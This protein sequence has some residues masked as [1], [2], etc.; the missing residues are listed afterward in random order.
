[1]TLNHPDSS[2]PA[3]AAAAA[4]VTATTTTAADDNKHLHNCFYARLVIPTSCW[5]IPLLWQSLLL[6]VLQLRQ[7]R[8]VAEEE[9]S[10]HW[11]TLMTCSRDV[12]WQLHFARSMSTSTSTSMQL[13]H[14]AVEAEAETEAV[15]AFLAWW[16]CAITL[17]LCTIWNIK[18]KLVNIITLS[19]IIK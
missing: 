12:C 8:A 15:R 7:L 9:D 6:L 2:K 4:A 11:A 16:C 14:G 13:V 18:C 10:P 19:T 1:M 3:S 5:V 17:L